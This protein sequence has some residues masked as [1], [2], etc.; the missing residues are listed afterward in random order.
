MIWNPGIPLS[1]PNPYLLEPLL[2]VRNLDGNSPNPLFYVPLII[3]GVSNNYI[4]NVNADLEEDNLKE[5]NNA[6]AANCFI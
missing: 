6:A 3:D 2:T 1:V 4:N 5:V